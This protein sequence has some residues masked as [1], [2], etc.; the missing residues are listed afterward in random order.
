[1]L[2]YLVII[3]FLTF[4]PAYS[5]TFFRLKS[6]ADITTN[7]SQATILINIYSGDKKVSHASGFFIDKK[8]SFL[9]NNHVMEDYFSISED[10]RKIEF[11]TN[12]G[13]RLKS[14]NIVRCE[15]ENNID[16]CLLQAKKMKPKAY[17]APKQVKLGLGHAVR[18]VG[19]CG[20]KWRIGKGEIIAI[21]NDFNAKYQQWSQ[22]KNLKTQMI[23]ISQNIC[24]GDS[25]GP[26][27]NPIN[28][29]LLGIVTKFFTRKKDNRVWNLGITTK[30]ISAF[31]KLPRR[32]KRIK[33]EN[34]VI[35]DPDQKQIMKELL[36]L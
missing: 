17:L 8:G 21:Y 26:I 13:Q 11:L 15:N 34:I 30:E 23:E 7:K 12:S 29:A 10:K 31:I 5:Q 27:F 2:R 20:G 14:V 33:Q 4:Q 35:E 3:I 6:A 9:T 36:Q 22:K 32:S 18:F 16:L 19:H 24:P 28:G 25:G 1:L